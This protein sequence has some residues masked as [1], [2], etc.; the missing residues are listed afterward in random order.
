MNLPRGWAVSC[1]EDTVEILDTF[2]KPINN[3]ERLQR[4]DGKTS[5]ELYPYYGATGLVGYIDE[6]M[7]DGEYVLLGEDAAPF[8]D[9]FAPK[10]YIV[11]GKIWV[12]NHAHILLS[13]L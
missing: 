10:A 6:Y 7:L 5:S 4:I 13:R 3:T 9:A 11:N 2:R 12:N 8:L 1:F